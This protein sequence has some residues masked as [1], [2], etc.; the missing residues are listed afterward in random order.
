M[1]LPTTK[2]PAKQ[3]IGALTWL[4]YGPPKIGKSTL[5]SQ[6]DNALFL[7][8]EA[9]LNSLEVFQIPIA[10]WDDFL[11]A[12]GLIKAGKHDYKTIVIDTVD[13]LHKLCAEHV[14]G[15]NGAEHESDLAYGKGYA[16]VNGEFQRVITKLA[17]MPFGL[18]MISHSK[19]QEKESRTGKY[20]KTTPTLTESIRKILLGMVDVIAFCDIE[21]DTENGQPVERRVIRTKPAKNYEAGDRTGRLPEVLPMDFAQIKAALSNDQNEKVE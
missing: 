1:E 13:M 20:V 4:I 14:L 15:K 7:A 21:A 19:E 12:C 16:L 17:A 9:G 6:A 8:T 11:S 3:E 2:T 5:A 18:I 10:S